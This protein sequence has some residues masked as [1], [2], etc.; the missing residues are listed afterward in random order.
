[1]TLAKARRLCGVPPAAKYPAS[2]QVYIATEAV[3]VLAVADLAYLEDS[4]VE[5]DML[6]VKILAAVN[7]GGLMRDDE[8]LWART[9]KKIA[10][11]VSHT[12]AGT[13]VGSEQLSEGALG[14]LSAPLK[15]AYAA[16]AAARLDIVMSEAA[17]VAKTAKPAADA[18]DS[19][20]TSPAKSDAST[21][22]GSV[23]RALTEAVN[24][25]K[26]IAAKRSAPLA[27]DRDTAAKLPPARVIYEKANDSV[28]LQ[29]GCLPLPIAMPIEED[30]VRCFEALSASPPRPAALDALE[31]PLGGRTLERKTTRSRTF[32]HARGGTAADEYDLL[33]RWLVAHAFG[34]A[35]PAGAQYRLYEEDE[36]TAVE[37]DV[38]DP[39]VE[40]CRPDLIDAAENAEAAVAAASGD[41]GE[42]G[43][44]G[45]APEASYAVLMALAAP[46]LLYAMAC[47]AA[48][49][50]RRLSARDASSYTDEVRSA[51]ETRLFNSKATFTQATILVEP[52]AIA[53][54]YAVGF[55]DRG[56]YD[57]GRD[58]GSDRDRDRDRGSGSDYRAPTRPG[59]RGGRNG[60]GGGGGGGGSAGKRPRGGDSGGSDRDEGVCFRWART[61]QCRDAEC[62]YRHWYRAGEEEEHGRSARRGA[63]PPRKGGGG[64]PRKGGGGK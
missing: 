23:A 57:R 26:D 61:G 50:Q 38:N 34:G 22:D 56:G 5:A 27:R 60:G 2:L 54:K 6:D 49:R 39:L 58:R 47:R 55:T 42:E 12:E 25:L 35:A 15:A 24:S 37:V 3:G 9:V 53:H 52:D 7:K 45:A 63:Q 13:L 19:A 62:F 43:D 30:V 10:R 51:L 48:G 28:Y 33:D 40:F 21:M 29:L 32:D 31:L 41:E 16:T 46:V 4:L 59:S 1:M 44:E 14:R 36:G 18:L 20:A 17:R 64:P 8:S 11:L